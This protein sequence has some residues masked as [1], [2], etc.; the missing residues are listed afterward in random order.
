MWHNGIGL[1]LEA[2]GNA[3]AFGAAADTSGGSVVGYDEQGLCYWRNGSRALLLENVGNGM[4][5]A[6]GVHE[7]NVYVTGWTNDANLVNAGY[8]WKN[9][10][11]T[12]LGQAVPNSLA[13]CGSD[14]L[15]G[16]HDSSGRC[17]WRNGKK[18]SVDIGWGIDAIAATSR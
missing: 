3:D 10:A 5:S 13:F 12:S 4:A 2:A 18:T 17:F 9:G 16:G 15:I 1:R 8:F 14:V 7:G 6:V 11:M